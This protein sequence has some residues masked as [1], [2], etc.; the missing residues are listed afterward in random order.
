MAY[1]V[2][3]DDI[4]VKKPKEDKPLNTFEMQEWLRC[5]QDRYYFFEN[6]CYIQSPMGKMLFK[7]RSYQKR[8]I[9]TAANNQFFV[10][11]SGRQTGKALDIDTPI[12]TPDGY[13]KM[14]DIEIGDYVIGPDGKPTLVTFTSPVMYGRTCYDVKFSTGESIIADAEHRWVV[15]QKG[16]KVPQL[17]NTQDMVDAGVITRTNKKRFS[18]EN[19]SPVEDVEH[20]TGEIT[21]ATRDQALEFHERLCKSGMA[22]NLPT[23]TQ[24]GWTV[25]SSDKT[26]RKIVSITPVRSRPVKCIQV[27]NTEHLY[28]VGRSHILTHNTEGFVIDILWEMTFFRDTRV[29]VTSYKDTNVN[30]INSRIRFCYESLPT[31][32][33]APVKKYNSKAIAFSN[34]SSVEFEVI[35]E[36]TFRGKSKT[37]ILV[38]EFAFVEPSI[39]EAFLTSIIPSLMGA[40]KKAKTKF[41]VISTPNGTS[42]EFAKMWFDAVS[43]KNGYAYTEVKY[44]EVPDRDEEFERAMLEKMTREKFLQEFKCHWIS[45]KKS[46]INGSYI[47]TIDTIDPV[48]KIGDLHLFVKREELA[49]RKLAMACDVSEGI[50]GDYHAFQ[51]FDIERME[52]VG[53]FQN[54]VLTQSMYVKQIL[55]AIKLMHESGAEEIYYTYENNA[56]GA[57]VARLLETSES[58]W[59]DHAMLISDING[60]KLGMNTNR[61]SK[62]KGCTQLKDLIEMGKMKIR[63][64]RLKTELQFFVK[65]GA[66]FA[67]E[68]GATDDLVMATVILC[69][70]LEILS[71]YEDSVYDTM[72]EIDGLDDEEDFSDIYF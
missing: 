70:M 7:P 37:R 18:I 29:G 67:A 4:L 14:G 23:K 51:I 11:L 30:D 45:T 50:G 55:N 33:K 3:D 2:D 53:E 9:D 31:F 24:L 56:I 8:I 36:S 47:E 71:N 21:F 66:S 22:P 1:A 10:G 26:H 43:G 68:D 25:K 59:L 20:F 40:G 69:N 35:K 61:S 54:N 46:L 62:D 48:E 17:V 28:A 41:Q 49:G 13:K 27:A 16:K 63:S 72:N 19:I 34:G 64:K 5:K 42:G 65:K 39:A 60:K 58:P 6:Y 32:L 15:N 52:Q 57:G 38:D 12:P 44:E